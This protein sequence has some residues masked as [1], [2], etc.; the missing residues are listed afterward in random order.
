[1]NNLERINNFFNFK[2][3]DR[4]PFVSAVYEHK[5]FLLGETPSDVA[6][7]PEKLFRAAVKE[8]EIYEPDFITVGMD[9]YNVEAESIGAEVTYFKNNSI[10]AIRKAI[11]KD[12]DDIEFLKIPDPSKSG[13]MPVMLEASKKISK[14]SRRS[15]SRQRSIQSRTRPVTFIL[16]RIN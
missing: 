11:I 5:A 16:M 15:C 12:I 3:V 13:R 6:R 1:M 8:Y 9:V 10:P 2:E 14:A 7:D 4:I